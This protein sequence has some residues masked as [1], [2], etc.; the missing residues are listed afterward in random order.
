M[1][2]GVSRKARAEWLLGRILAVAGVP[3][4]RWR[5][6]ESPVLDVRLWSESGEEAAEVLQGVLDD[7]MRLKKG[8]GDWW[9]VELTGDNPEWWVGRYRPVSLRLSGISVDEVDRNW[10]QK[11]E[12][13]MWETADSALGL[14]SGVLKDCGLEKEG[15]GAV[16]IA[17]KRV[18]GRN[19][20]R[21]ARQV[22]REMGVSGCGQ[23]V[24]QRAGGWGDSMLTGV[25]G[26]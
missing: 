12:E 6:S 19:M 1:N 4:E 22:V 11:V 21:K 23:E 16:R 25:V 7:R 2:D 17:C 20:A 18:G 8:N 15:E 5:L 13:R 9:R 14:A 26:S 24:L 10:L 3:A